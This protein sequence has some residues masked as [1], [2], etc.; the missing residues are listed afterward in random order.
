MRI[1]IDEEI[2]EETDDGFYVPLDERTAKEFLEKIPLITWHSLRVTFVNEAVH[3]GVSDHVVGLQAHWKMAGNMPDKYT[4]ERQDIP[5]IMMKQLVE[6]VKNDWAPIARFPNEDPKIIVRDEF[7]DDEIMNDPID[8]EARP[9]FYI[10]KA[11]LDK[12]S[13]RIIRMK[14]HISSIGDLSTLACGKVKID[15]CDPL[16]SDEPDPGVLCSSCVKNRCSM[17]LRSRPSDGSA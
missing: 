8:V 16:G 1:L 17:L 9:M 13:A 5:M 6:E 2:S 4:R 14:V 15:D 7:S 12:V 3:K 10:K 11:S